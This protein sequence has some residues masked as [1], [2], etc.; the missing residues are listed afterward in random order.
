MIDW[1]DHNIAFVVTSY[2]IVFCVLAV[3]VAATLMRATSLRKTLKAMNLPDTGR[4]QA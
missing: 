1:T 2:A 3:V 4:D